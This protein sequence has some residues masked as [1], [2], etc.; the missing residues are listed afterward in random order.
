MTSP[1]ENGLLEVNSVQPFF[2]DTDD[3]MSEPDNVKLAVSL[4]D[5]Q[6]LT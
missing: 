2:C 1:I 4:P 5:L 6:E 3:A